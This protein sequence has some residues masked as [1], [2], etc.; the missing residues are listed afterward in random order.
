MPTSGKG[1]E[2]VYNA[3]SAVDVKNHLDSSQS[4]H[5]TQS[6][7]DKLEIDPTLQSLNDLPQELGEIDGQ[8]GDAGYFS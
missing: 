7:N 5:V 3:Q 2:Q 8:L 4:N 1:F 6:T